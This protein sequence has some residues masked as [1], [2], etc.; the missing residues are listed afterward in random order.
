MMSLP[1]TKKPKNPVLV[2]RVVGHSMLP[3]LPPGTLVIG[4]TW[5]RKPLKNS[6]VVVEHEGKEKIKRIQ[7]ID[8]DK[9]FIVGDHED[10]ST[11]SRQFGWVSI[12]TIKAHIV[13]PKTNK[14]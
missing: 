13:W 3:V 8:N 2:R 4:L 12:T 9:I 11:D 5:L 7:D 1:K 14:L 10:G 6:V